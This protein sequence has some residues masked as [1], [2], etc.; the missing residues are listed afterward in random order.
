[1]KKNDLNKNGVL[2]SDEL[3]RVT[4]SSKSKYDKDRNGKITKAE[5]LAAQYP[6]KSITTTKSSSNRNPRSSKPRTYTKNS[7]AFNKADANKDRL[8][9]MHE[10]SKTWTQKKLDEFLDKDTNLSLIH[11]S[12][13]TRPY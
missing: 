7:S 8:V 4:K 6:P 3:K 11:I 12:E 10:F 2:E 5:V 13:P 9:Q 1:M